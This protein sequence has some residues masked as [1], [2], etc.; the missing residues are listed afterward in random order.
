MTRAR[1]FVWWTP[2][3]VVCDPAFGGMDPA[4]PATVVEGFVVM[5]PAPF[6]DPTGSGALANALGAAGAA[7]KA[8]PD[9]LGALLADGLHDLQLQAVFH[10]DPARRQVKQ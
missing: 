8:G 9:R 5:V 10:P 4:P 2:T 1:W 3:G 6:N 7:V